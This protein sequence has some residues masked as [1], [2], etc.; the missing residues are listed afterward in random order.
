MK[1]L[2]WWHS[3]HT[4][5]SL[6]LIIIAAVMIEVS[7]AVQFYFARN[8]I[9]KEVDE[10]AQSEMKMKSLKIQKVVS[11]VESA[12][13]NIDRLLDWSVEN[14]NY[15]YPILEE[16]VESNE[17]IQGCAIAFEPNYFPKKGR[18]FEPYVRRDT[19]GTY[20]RMQIAN[21]SHDYHNMSWYKEGRLADGGLWTEPYIDNE[22]ALGLICSYT[23]PVHNSKG[24]VV[25][26]FCADMLLDWL[27]EEFVLDENTNYYSF[28]VSREGRMLACPDKS[29]IMNYTLDDASNQFHD[30]NIPEV[31]KAMLAGKSGSAEVKNNDGELSY[32]YYSPVEGNT[33]WSMA[34]LF[35]DREI[36]KG[37]RDIAFKL[38]I[39]MF[40]GLTL[41]I[42][43]MWRA[44]KGFKRL[45]TVN[46]EK[47]R[48]GSELRIASAIQ[49]GMLPKTFPPYPDLDELSM[50]GTLVPA[51]EVG[52][53]LYDFYVRD[54]KL[55]F[56]LGDV[57][58]KGVPASLVMAV[59]RSLFR[60]VSAHIVEPGKV[61][62]QLNEA[63]SEMNENSMFVT[64]FIGVLDL[65]TGIL[66]YCNAGHCPPIVIH[67]GSATPI[68]MD[69]NIPVGLMSD[70]QYT[71]QNTTIQP[72]SRLFLY[73]DGL[74][75]A[76]DAEHRQ[77]GEER[78]FA[79][80]SQT[81]SLAPRDLI[82]AMTESVHSFVAGA[83]QSDDLTMLAIQ[84]IKTINA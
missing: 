1:K 44:V 15:I 42:Y 56:C 32:M 13:E 17:C 74:T 18:W 37:L 50:F 19:N 41:M 84:F 79:A 47:E 80:L 12:V 63:M 10:R 81:D 43:I 9:Q 39:L 51:K 68:V 73:T 28:I 26:V 54:Q 76:E 83:E 25:A 49:M 24:E 69:A 45:Q 64:L 33:G 7:G 2:K 38:G 36:Y 72:G 21:E 48:I 57:S 62:T 29:L 40:L 8:G 11:S 65:R 58:G 70:W 3:L 71:Q 46:A 22:G 34:I 5:S 60:T 66:A 30:A 82:A 55:F 4:R 67:Q 16:F 31:N 78:M 53:D 52:G 61:M 14:P 77:Y 27:T 59:T 35:P 6:A 75:E 23:L 20:L